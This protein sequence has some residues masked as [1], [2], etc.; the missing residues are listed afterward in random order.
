LLMLKKYFSEIEHDPREKIDAVLSV[1]NMLDIKKETELKINEHHEKALMLLN[2]LAV[3]QER[4]KVL[5]GFS[6]ELMKREK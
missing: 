4:K 5:I 1:F 3:P 6:E 2:E